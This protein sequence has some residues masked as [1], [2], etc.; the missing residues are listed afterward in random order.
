MRTISS[1]Q[2]R[3]VVAVAMFAAPLIL[4][5]CSDDA[6]RSLG[7]GPAAANLQAAQIPGNIAALSGN[8]QVALRGNSLAQPLTLIVRDISGNS[9]SGAPVAF[10][11]TSGRARLSIEQ[12]V[13]DVNGRVSTA[14]NLISSGTITG[15]AT[16]AGAP[17]V[18]PVT[19]TFTAI[20]AGV[21][22]TGVGTANVAAA[23]QALATTIGGANNGANPPALESGRRELNCDAVLLNGTDFGTN[24]TL[25]ALNDNTG[26]PANR[27]QARGALFD[28][29]TSVADDGFVSVNPGVAGAFAAFSP[30]NTFAPFGA[31]NRVTTMF[32]R[33][34][35]P[36]TAP[37]AA[38]VGAF[39]AIFL[40]VERPNTS[41]IEYFAGP[42]SLGRFF[43]PTGPSGQPEFLGVKFAD[44]VVTHVVL[45][46]GEAPLFKFANGVLMPG[47]ADLSSGGAVDQVA[48]DDFIYTEPK[49]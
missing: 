35:A 9:V 21:P 10:T 29:T 18:V 46:T 30:A 11:I 5:G 22:F 16:V 49:L 47:A 26:I 3:L 42:N 27:F 8:D 48:L 36:S 39:G 13:T 33:A 25:I 43:V 37:I 41:S 6:I 7:G 2:R 1:R 38:K 17:A 32:V 28:R 31:D 15:A 4:V 45:T 40:D 19:F 20:E 34:S 24:T 44:S 12:G 23:F 14:V